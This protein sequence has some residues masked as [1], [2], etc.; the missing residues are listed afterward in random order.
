VDALF[1]LE[2]SPFLSIM[3]IQIFEHDDLGSVRTFT[4]DGVL[5]FVASDVLN[6][7]GY[8]DHKTVIKRKV[9]DSFLHPVDTINR[10]IQNALCFSERDFYYVTLTSKTELGESF[11]SWVFKDV[12]PNIRKQQRKHCK[13][14]RD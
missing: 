2:P 7:L 12:L 6:C 13:I 5:C 4:K 8:K 14:L 9:K 3:N 10:G 1:L 11:R